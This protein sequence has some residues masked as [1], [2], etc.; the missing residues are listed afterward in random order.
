MLVTTKKPF[1]IEREHAFCG[2][3]GRERIPGG[4]MLSTFLMCPQHGEFTP[5]PVILLG[6]R[7]WEIHFR[8]E[9][10]RQ[11]W[12]TCAYISE[13]GLADGSA[14]TGPVWSGS[15]HERRVA[16]PLPDPGRRD[17]LDGLRAKLLRLL[18]G[19]S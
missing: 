16:R 18:R 10:E 7:G 15:A 5:G 17:G 6:A 19:G 11:S 13:Q 12:E 3:C 1:D 9:G 4:H 14:Q 2:F 8:D